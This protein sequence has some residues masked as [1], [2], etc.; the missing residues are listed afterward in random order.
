ML[1]V[2]Y[3]NLHYFG[4]GPLIILEQSKTFN[5]I[6]KVF[7][8]PLFFFISGFSS[9]KKTFSTKKKSISSFLW[10]KFNALIIPSLVFMLLYIF[11]FDYPFTLV[12]ADKMK[13]GYWFTITLFEFFVFYAVTL[14]FLQR[15]KI[16]DKW[17]DF[18]LIIVSLF[19]C[20]FSVI[21]FLGV[22]S[23]LFGLLSVGQWNFYFFFII[24]VFCRKYFG[25]FQSF[26]DNSFIMGIVLVSFI[27]AIY[28]CYA[29]RQH[30]GLLYIFFYILLGSVS[31][32]IFFG[33]FRKYQNGFSK[34]TILG[35]W[36]QYI[37]KHTLE[38]YLLHYFF[39][40]RNLHFIGDYF[41]LNPSPVLEFFIS[42][43]IACMVISVCLVLSSVIRISDKFDFVLFGKTS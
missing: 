15:L 9:Y 12:V 10:K 24:G 38:I 30:F 22:K 4:Y 27:I 32:F 31:P 37:G 21:Q 1:L 26:L 42:M 39:L 17:S 36:L 3:H 7:F 35:R 2:V 25:E 34:Q 28:F 8:M 16:S 33:F 6:I 14:L 20:G 29:E 18:V 41:A 43:L 40:P 5:D 13:V 11:L 19:I 23:D